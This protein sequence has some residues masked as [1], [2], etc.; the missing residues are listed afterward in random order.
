MG[1]R[2][3]VDHPVHMLLQ[4]E[5]KHPLEVADVH[6]DEPVVG[7]VFNVLEIREI[8]RIGEFVQVDDPVV[9]ILVHEQPHDM[10][11][12]E[13]GA[14]GNEDGSIAHKGKDDVCLFRKG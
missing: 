10:A 7:P 11:A 12:D 9:R 2:R 13:A 5:G 14:A 1:F 6:F 3:E 4:H 8:A